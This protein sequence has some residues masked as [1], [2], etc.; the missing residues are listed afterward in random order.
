[1]YF[2]LLLF[3]LFLFLKIRPFSLFLW[4]NTC[5][6]LWI[7]PSSVPA[8][9]QLDWVSINFRECPMEDISSLW[10]DPWLLTSGPGPIWPCK[11][12]PWNICPGNIYPC[13]ICPCN[14]CSCNICPCNICPCNICPFNICPCNICPGTKLR[15][16]QLQLLQRYLISWLLLFQLGLNNPN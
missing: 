4:S 1:M 3:G 16:L 12:C 10:N 15:C 13:N 11:I 7:L 14:I 8:P 2:L 6:S 9:A 5:N